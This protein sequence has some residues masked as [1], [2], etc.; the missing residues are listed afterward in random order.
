MSWAIHSAAACNADTAFTSETP[1]D[2]RGPSKQDTCTRKRLRNIGVLD[3]QVESPF[4]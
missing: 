1:S 4:L 3:F 2:G